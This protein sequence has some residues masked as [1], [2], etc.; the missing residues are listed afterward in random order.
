MEASRSLHANAPPYIPC[1]EAGTD[2]APPPKIGRATESTGFAAVMFHL[3]NPPFPT[4]TCRPIPC[5]YIHDTGEAR[6]GRT[7][8]YITGSFAWQVAGPSRQDKPLTASISIFFPSMHAWTWTCLSIQTSVFSTR[9]GSG[10][11]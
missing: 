11:P 1:L 7:C 5:S 3:L 8:G 10:R 2:I 4:R 6:P 9:A